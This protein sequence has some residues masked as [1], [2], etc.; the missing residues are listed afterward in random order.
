MP[1]P[2]YLSGLS[3]RIINA[4]N[5]NI[6]GAVSA[7]LQLFDV[8]AITANG[9][10]S[11]VDGTLLTPNSDFW[12]SDYIP[13]IAGLQYSQTYK[14]YIAWFSSPSPSGFISGT[15]PTT[16]S[17]TNTAPVG[18]A[19]LRVSGRIS[20]GHSAADMMV[21]QSA[22]VL[23]WQPYGGLVATDRLR[24]AIDPRVNTLWPNRSDNLFDWKDP[25][26]QDG[27]YQG[28]NGVVST[29]ATYFISDFVPVTVGQTYSW[30]SGERGARSITAYD[31]STSAVT[32]SGSDAQV[33]SWT[34]PTGIVAIKFTT[35]ATAA[36]AGVVK[37]KA[38]ASVGSMQ[39]WG[40]KLDDTYLPYL[41]DLP[42]TEGLSRMRHCTLFRAKREDAQ[43]ARLSVVLVGDSYTDA[44]DRYAKKLLDRLVVAYGDGGGGWTGYGFNSGAGPFTVGG[45][46]PGGI[47]GNPRPA[48]YTLAYNGAWT[49][50][51]NFTGTP[52]PDL[53]L[54]ESSSVGAFI[55]RTV[56]A[57]PDHT[58]LRLVW[59]GTADG[60]IRYQ[61]DG[62]SWTSANT[63]GTVGN[64][65]YTDVTLTVGAH[66]VNIEVVSGTVK[67]C[68]DIAVSATNGVV[69]HK[70]G[71]SGGRIDAF[72]SVDATQHL[73]ALT[74]LAPDAA[75]IFEGTN[76][77]GNGTAGNYFNWTTNLTTFVARVRSAG[78]NPD[79][80]MVA[81]PENGLG[82]V[83]PMSDYAMQM[84][85]L[86][87]T[88]K[89]AFLDLQRSF[90]EQ[91]S[92]YDD[93][94]T[95]PLFQS[96]NTHPTPATG[97]YIMALEIRRAMG[98]S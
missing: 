90:G 18:A 69:F 15:E 10:I 81:P 13:V 60:V 19:F 64:V 12:T 7:S 28:A 4:I 33:T 57:A 71:I 34:C 9:F 29:N 8:T 93:T 92:D 79:I 84:R 77:Q 22:T 83:N 62:G 73:A 27:K 49:G 74:L 48:S 94:G 1:T 41:A 26:V 70:L 55:R 37:M 24:G 76:S 17:R 31:A 58:A 2:P 88:I 20:L 32:G 86:S 85:L 87:R 91:Y 45:T 51:A 5:R 30:G 80:L 6:F 39:P 44:Y 56:P 38:A 95:W 67:L 11:H 72:T 40:F 59:I 96:D 36:K 97:G 35:W 23:S 66:T 75:I 47:H 54:I 16:T 50:P 78:A 25:Q 3:S 68:G 89:T 53:G 61:V 82:R 43:A 46:Q 98:L 65:G 14:S 63:Q 42:A 52:S 21:S